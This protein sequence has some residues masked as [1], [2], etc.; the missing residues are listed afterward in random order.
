MSEKEPDQKS[1]KGLEEEE[2]ED[3]DE[4]KPDDVK[5]DEGSENES[6]NDDESQPES[7]KNND[8]KLSSTRSTRR[9]I[10]NHNKQF[11]S[12][13][14]STIYDESKADL[15]WKN[16]KSSSSVTTVI[17][18]TPP[19]TT[20]A[21][22]VPTE[23]T[24]IYEFAGETVVL[25]SIQPSMSTTISSTPITTNSSKPL[26]TTLKRPSGGSIGANALLDH[27]GINKK[28]KLSTLE[29]TRLDWNQHKS[30]ESLTDE[31]NL[32]RRGKN[33]YVEKVAF[34]QRAD[35]LEY[36]HQRLNFKKK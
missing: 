5:T 16:F 1:E 23:T 7:D 2:E 36:E 18:N 27:L 13:Q 26:P 20:S 34:L 9:N 4:Y 29:K 17:T 28:Q 3:D 30:N 35:T 31:L 25:P 33:S 6:E 22:A 8:H 12:D 14:I 11:D 15:L 24:K 10:I 21:T 19:K 32:H